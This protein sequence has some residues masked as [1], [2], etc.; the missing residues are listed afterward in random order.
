MHIT[1]DADLR[2]YQHAQTVSLCDKLNDNILPAINNATGNTQ[3]TADLVEST[4]F[5][6]TSNQYEVST[7]CRVFDE[8]TQITNIPGVSLQYVGD[9]F[10]TEEIAKNFREHLSDRQIADMSK[11]PLILALDL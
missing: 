1:Q 6:R 3:I 2:D 5:V 9:T 7:V 8:N 10:D 4:Y 11:S